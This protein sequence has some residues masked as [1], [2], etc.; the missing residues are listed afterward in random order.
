MDLSHN[1]HGREPSWQSSRLAIQERAILRIGIVGGTGAA[2]SS[3]GLRLSSL[4]HE[5]LLGSRTL[6][7]ASSV[8]ESLMKLPGQTGTIEGV[9]NADAAKGELVFIA[10]PWDGAQSTVGALAKELSGK[11]VVSMVNALMKVGSEMQPVFPAR[12]SVAQSIQAA[13]PSCFVVSAL[14]HVPAK[15]L[16]EIGISVESDILVCSDHADSK[17]QVME[18]LDSVPGLFSLDCGSLAN[19]GA[20]EAMTAVLINLN[21]RYKTRTAL[22]IT[23]LRRN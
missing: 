3:L 13:L 5:I 11:T 15:E 16:G 20:I 21:I 22:R 10:T 1:R 18:L 2:G 19:S 7:K 17:K 8:A 14:H 23:G 4:G 12:G 6:E 9:V